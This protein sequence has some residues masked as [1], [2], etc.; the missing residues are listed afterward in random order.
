ML[1]QRYV[2]SAK[3]YVLPVPLFY[4]EIF[5]CC[6]FMKLPSALVSKTL[7]HEEIIEDTIYYMCKK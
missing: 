2:T 7:Y 5:T 3:L 4:T 6:V 1:L